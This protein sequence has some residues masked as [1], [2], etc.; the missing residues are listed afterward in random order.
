MD[1]AG[2][3]WEWLRRDPAYINWYKIASLAPRAS[4]SPSIWGLQFAEAPDT[5]AQQARIIW[6]A[7]LDPATLAIA[8]RP[9]QTAGPDLVDLDDL[10]PWLTI[11][12]GDNGWQHAVLSDGRNRIRLD[13]I[14]GSLATRG[15][16][17]I[18]YRIAGTIS[19]EA[20]IMPLRRFLYLARHRRF[21]RSLFPADPKTRRWIVLLRVHDALGAGASQREIANILFGDV[22]VTRDW[23]GTSD[24][25]RSRVRRLAYDA[26]ALAQGGYRHLMRRNC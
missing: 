20:R 25:L 17:L 4:A 24:S 23:H 22:R 11:A 13:V 21:S 8:V 7:A 3:M 14:E 16:A 9:A 19:A 2:I 10:T 12:N 5:F 1:R 18:E 6:D 15:R 26:R